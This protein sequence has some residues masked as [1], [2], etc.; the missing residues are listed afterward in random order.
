M[1]GGHYVGQEVHVDCYDQLSLED[2]WGHCSH[3]GGSIP[4]IWVAW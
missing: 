1:G 2:L 4:P 3:L